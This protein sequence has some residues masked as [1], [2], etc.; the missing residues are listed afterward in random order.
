MYICVMQQF[1]NDRYTDHD[2]VYGMN[3]NVFYKQELDKLPPGKLLLPGEGEARNAIYAAKQGWD[4]T[5]FDS[6][7]KA[8]E[9]G[10]GN[11]KQAAVNINYI[12]ADTASFKVVPNTFNA[13]ALVYFHLLPEQRIP[14]HQKL[15]EWLKPGGILII[16]CF[17]PQQLGKLSGGPKDINMLY[18]EEMLRNDFSALNIKE[19][20]TTT[21]VLDEGDF[22]KGEAELIRF[23]ATK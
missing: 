9:K 1:W 23:V 20:F 17:N 10:L 13:I 15:I 21:Q 12:H 16:E 4:V 6:S 18:S 8:V 2:N 22:H 7:N 19:C 3:P 14:F 11:A 5:A